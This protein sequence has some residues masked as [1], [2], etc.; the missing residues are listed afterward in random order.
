M[1]VFTD[2]K[3]LEYFTTTKVLN[4]KQAQWAEELAK[5][6]FVIYYCTEALNMKADLLS[7]RADYAPEGEE[8]TM[9]EPPLLC[10]GQWIAVTFGLTV[11][12]L[13]KDI[14]AQLKETYER[15]KACQKAIKEVWSRSKLSF[16]LSKEGVLLQKDQ[17]Y[18]PDDRKI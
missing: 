12:S 6:N 14:A 15:D 1:K 9:A 2:Y 11:F 17:I 13:D 18:I 8:A 10:P 4:K 16:S 3:N 7:C 5:Y